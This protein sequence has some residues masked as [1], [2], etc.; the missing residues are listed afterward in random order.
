MDRKLARERLL[1]GASF[2][3]L[4][5][6]VWLIRAIIRVGLAL[7]IVRPVESLGMLRAARR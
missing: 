2:R 6:I 7:R 3:Q 5:R 1:R 4:E